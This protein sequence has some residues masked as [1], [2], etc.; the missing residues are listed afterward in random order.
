MAVANA[1]SFKD[2]VLALGDGAGP[3][4]FTPVGAFL[5]RSLKGKLDTYSTDVPDA[6]DDSAIMTREIEGKSLGWE[7][8]ADGILALGGATAPASVMRAWFM[9]AVPK[10]CTLTISGTLAAGGGAYSGSFWLTDFNI[11]AKRGEK[12]T[13]SVTLMAGSGVIWTPAGA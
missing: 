12:A 6:T 1:L 9:S 3:E 10:N 5:S 11:A 7:V 2:F 4:V 8:S 13:V